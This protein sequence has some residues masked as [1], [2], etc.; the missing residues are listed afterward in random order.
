MLGTESHVCL[1]IGDEESKLIIDGQERNP[2]V[3]IYE[4][5]YSL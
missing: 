5:M 4:G 1:G 2:E 3:R